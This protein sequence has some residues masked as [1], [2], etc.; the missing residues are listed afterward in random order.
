M[1]YLSILFKTNTGMYNFALKIEIL[2]LTF[3]SYII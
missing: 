3:I 1:N 2:I